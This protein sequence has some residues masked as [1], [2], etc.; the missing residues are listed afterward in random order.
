MTHLLNHASTESLTIDHSGLLNPDC[1]IRQ[2]MTIL[3][4]KWV[5]H[6]LVALSTGTKRTGQ[7]KRMLLN[8]SP[9]VLT[10]TLRKLE[11]HGLVCRVVYNEVPPR[12]EYSLTDLGKTL[13]TPIR[14]LK[15]W[16]TDHFDEMIAFRDS[17]NDE[18]MDNLP[19]LTD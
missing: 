12:V 5:L 14:A 18:L 9:K 3:S 2:T 4:D 7:I 6:V 13:Q 19:E 1:P 11:T 16:A 17:H 8:I 10:Q 15:L